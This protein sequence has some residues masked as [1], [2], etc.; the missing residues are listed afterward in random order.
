MQLWSQDV[1]A[2][3]SISSTSQP[4]Y[5]SQLPQWP[6]GAVFESDV[7]SAI[8][9]A[10]LHL[11]GDIPCD[12]RHISPPLPPSLLVSRVCM[13]C[14]KQKCLRLDSSVNYGHFARWAIYAA[15]E[16][17][18]GTI[19]CFPHSYFSEQKT[20]FFFCQ[21]WDISPILHVFPYSL[22]LQQ[23][24]LLPDLRK[25]QLS[26]LVSLEGLQL[27]QLWQP[28]LAS[29]NYAMMYML[30]HVWA[31]YIL[32]RCSDIPSLLPWH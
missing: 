19:R 10:N 5:F 18:T 20:C 15:P 17:S 16:F 7:G 13:N 31:Q 29:W 14:S 32:C 8:E 24:S 6:C 22:V 26:G 28:C 23:N 2:Y 9:K 27:T 3:L 11:K 21:C 4:I 30:N 12:W 25:Q 1:E